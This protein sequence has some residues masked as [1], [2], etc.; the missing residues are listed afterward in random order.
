[1]LLLLLA[2]PF[3]VVLYVR[4]SRRG[5]PLPRPLRL[6]GWTCL[7]G[8]VLLVLTPSKWAWHFGAFAG[9]ATIFLSCA[10]LTAPRLVKTLLDDRR[11]LALGS[12]A[13]LLAGTGGWILLSGQG[14]NWWADNLMPGVPRGGE[15]LLTGAT[16]VLVVTTAAVVGLLVLRRHKQHHRIHA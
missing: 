7:L 2:L 5:R 3:F 11:G 4:A 13:L 15:P 14:E 6:T 16:A 9:V 8:L 1:V 12:G 10:A